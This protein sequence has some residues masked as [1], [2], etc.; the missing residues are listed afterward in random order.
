MIAMRSRTAAFL[1]WATA[2]ICI[3]L[4]FA[5]E[6]KFGVRSLDRLWDLGHLPAFGLF[7]YLLVTR[8]KVLA[9][10][11]FA[12]QLLI[13]LLLMGAFGWTVEILQLLVGRT[14]SW[15][16]LR[17]DLLGASTALAFGAPGPKGLKNYGRAALKTVV[18]AL[19]LLEAAPM[20]RACIDEFIAWRQ[21]PVLSDFETPFE[22]ERWS[23]SAHFEIDR[24]IHRLGDASLRVDLGTETYSGAGMNFFP[25]DW[26][27]QR[28]LCIELY[29]PDLD[30][31]VLTCRVNDKA[32]NQ[33]G[34]HYA[35]RFNRAFTLDPGWHTLEIP[36]ETIRDAPQG[37]A[38]DLDDIDSFMLFA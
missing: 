18:V 28:F 37:R 23:G 29:N 10:R 30:P 14:F 26:R 8:W 36:I 7:A 22:R 2:I 25:R 11:P 31:I 6:G 20:A 35:D 19:I 9:R 38:M 17:K 3:I 27:G 13:A 21:F 33:R 24:S 4:L 32:H 34:Y 5:G 1:L 15:L 12:Q 16:D